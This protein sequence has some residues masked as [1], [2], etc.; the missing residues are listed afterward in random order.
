MPRPE[1]ITPDWAA[2]Q[3]VQAVST[4]RC[5]GFSQGCYAGF[6]LGMHV[7]DQQQH[8]TRNHQLLRDT[9]L[10]PQ[11]PCWLEQQHGTR[12]VR[13]TASRAGPLKADA[14]FTT[15]PGVVCAVQTAD[16]LPVLFCD[17]QARC[18]AVAHGG[19]RGLLDGVLESTLQAMPVQA[20]DL[21]CWLGPAIGPG[22]F[23]IDNALGESFMK[24]DPCLASA[25]T[26]GRA[27]KCLAD[28]YR[29][30]RHTLEGRGVHSVGGGGHC[31]Y[32][33]SR[34]YFSH[35]RDG[36]TGRMATLIWL[37]PQ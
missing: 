20:S 5:G 22:K 6:N 13:L 19:W 31:T 3:G 36:T 33:Q 17:R 4:T 28:I 9:L 10:L 1:C 8:V 14:A 24:K 30:A 2:P 26:P 23:E 32:T 35:R 18:V 15:I 27:G 21:M 25:F 12:V 34:E 29:I 16:C 11:D 7:G 37:Q